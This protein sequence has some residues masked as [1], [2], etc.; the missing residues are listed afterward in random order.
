MPSRCIAVVM[1]VAASAGA[2]TLVTEQFEGNLLK[3]Q[4]GVWNELYLLN[5]SATQEFRI[6]TD[7]TAKLRG[8]RGLLIHDASSTAGMGGRGFLRFNIGTTSNAYARFWASAEGA[9]DRGEQWAFFDLASDPASNPTVLEVRWVTQSQRFEVGCLDRHGTYFIVGSGLLRSGWSLVE[10]GFERAGTAS[11]RCVAYLN[12]EYLGEQVRDQTNR[13]LTHVTLG[14]HFA[15]NLV[16]GTIK[17]DD[18]LFD[19][20]PVASRLRLIGGELNVGGCS[21]VNVGLSHSFDGGAVAAPWPETI[22]L[23]TD[24]GRATLWADEACQTPA[25]TVQLMPGDMNTAFYV[26]AGEPGPMTVTASSPDLLPETKLLT[27]R[28]GDPWGARPN[29]YG[30]ACSN[31]EGI[32]ALALLMLMAP[33]ARCRLR[34]AGCSAS[35]TDAR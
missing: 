13:F 28:V 35:P 5:P 32:E 29:L 16:T 31:V 26:A 19:T 12:G 17:V 14:Q 7:A 23:S 25:T 21:R 24:G 10:V 34:R 4:G 33:L 9:N 8:Q 22:E 18:L 20:T 30:L 15:D 1:L 27:A 2:Q 6:V 11:G 3:A